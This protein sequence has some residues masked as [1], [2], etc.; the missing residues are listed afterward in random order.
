MQ[1]KINKEKL[2]LI[3]RIRKNTLDYGIASLNQRSLVDLT[4]LALI[5]E[6]ERVQK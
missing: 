4:V 1:T 5:Y 3:R 6:L 2:D